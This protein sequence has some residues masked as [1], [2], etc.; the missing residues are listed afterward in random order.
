VTDLVHRHKVRVYYEDTDFSG[1]VY[2]ASYLR[3]LERGR[4]EFLRQVGIDHRALF[5]VSPP[6]A[7]VVRRMSIA[8]DKP[9]LMDDMLE[10]E[11][12]LVELG[13]ASMELAQ[14]IWRGDE[15][16][17]GAEV[18]VACIAGS[19]PARLPKALRSAMAAWLPG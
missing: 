3:F 10:V 4:T 17:L 12:S 5:A 2:H 19:R 7:L 9:A 18:T 11:T 15:K 1:L 8:F 13:G 16:L 6:T 14:S